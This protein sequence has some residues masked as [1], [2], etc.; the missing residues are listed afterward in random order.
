VLSFLNSWMTDGELSRLVDQMHRHG[1]L[2]NSLILRTLCQGEV[3][4]FETAMAK[5]NK[6]PLAN[7]RKLLRDLG[8]S[9]FYAIYRSSG[10]PTDY[11]E[12]VRI[13]LRTIYESR[14]KKVQGGATHTTDLANKMR[15]RN[16]HQSIAGMEDLLQYMEQPTS[17]TRQARAA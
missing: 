1:R 7:A 2:S 8:E 4:F 6:I 9:G 12:A 3:N 13:L 5:R 15:A 11:A 14:G 17:T 10:L 16:Y